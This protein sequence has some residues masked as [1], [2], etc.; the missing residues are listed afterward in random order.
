M[1][2][3]IMRALYPHQFVNATSLKP[4]SDAQSTEGV[5]CAIQ[6]DTEDRLLGILQPHDKKSL[7]RAWNLSAV[8]LRYLCPPYASRPWMLVGPFPP[9]L[10]TG[11]SLALHF[12]AF[13]PRG[14][15]SAVF[16]QP[17]SV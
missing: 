9:F 3:S 14:V 7:R 13:A 4:L 15:R 11:F 17:L 5:H 12:V 1:R 16:K 6:D 2:S 8:W 10:A